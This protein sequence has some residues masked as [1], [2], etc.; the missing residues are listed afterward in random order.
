[1]KIT[2]TT[3]KDDNY[4]E[5][6]EFISRLTLPTNTLTPEFD[7]VTVKSDDKNSVEWIAT[8]Q[9]TTSEIEKNLNHYNNLFFDE[10]E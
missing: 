3:E 8:W 1:M 6:E 5:V 2:I 4:C 7:E 10:N 9:M